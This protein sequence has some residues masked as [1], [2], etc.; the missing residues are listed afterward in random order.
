MGWS[1]GIHK[2][3]TNFHE[4]WMEY[5]SLPRIQPQSLLV[6][7]CIMGKELRDRTF[8]PIYIFQGVMTLVY[9]GGRYLS[10]GLKGGLLGLG[11]GISST[12]CYS[13]FKYWKILLLLPP[14]M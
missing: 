2:N 6:L 8:L 12:E 10:G 7:V 11:G 3:T 13:C 14:K 4:T 1:T 5:G 9:S